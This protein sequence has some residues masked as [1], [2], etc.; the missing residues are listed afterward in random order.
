MF[1]DF[2]GDKG[3]ARLAYGK[4]FTFY[5]VKDVKFTTEPSTHDI[6][7]MYECESRAFLD[8]VVT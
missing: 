2:L 6:P 3:G 7:N 4:G 8:T 5:T 1:V